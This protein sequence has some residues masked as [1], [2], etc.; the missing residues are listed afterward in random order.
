MA[1][2]LLRQLGHGK[3]L[4]TGRL[5]QHFL[6][7][8][9]ELQRHTDTNRNDGDMIAS[10]VRDRQRLTLTDEILAAVRA[11]TLLLWG[12]DE[13]F[14]GLDDPVGAARSTTAFLQG[15]EFQTGDS[16]LG[17]TERYVP[18]PHGLRAQNVQDHHF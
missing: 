16:A 8:Y 1:T 9:L 17:T 2:S 3:S 11:P 18:A 14:A 12:E 4:D 13:T 6:D 10:A 5:P 7:W 15:A